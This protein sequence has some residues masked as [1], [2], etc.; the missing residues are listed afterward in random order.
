MKRTTDRFLDRLYGYITFASEDLKLFQTKELA[1]LRQVSLS[2]IPT[3]ITP[4][5]VCASKFEHSIGVAHLARMIGK[6]PEFED[7]AQDLFMAALTHDIGTPPFSHASELFLEKLYKKNHEE[8]AREIIDGSEFEKEAKRQGGDIDRI[9]AFIEGTDEPM[10]DI[11]NGSID[12]DNL[13]NSLRFGLSMGIV[14]SI[15]YSPEE[16]AESYRMVDGELVLLE[17]DERNLDGWDWVRKMVYTYVYSEMNLA[18]G[19]VLIRAMDYAMRANELPYEYFMMTDAQ[20]FEYLRTKTNSKTQRLLDWAWRMVFFNRAYSYVSMKSNE[21]FDKALT[22][23][24]VRSDIADQIAQELKVDPE[25]VCVHV[26]KN[27]GFKKI[28]LPIINRYGEKEFRTPLNELTYMVQVYV[29]PD[30]E[31]DE[32]VIENLVR[33]KLCLSS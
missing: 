10:S 4:T 6:K 7:V 8:F 32:Q 19:T 24:S 1:R 2:A 33:D 5:S 25:K 14:N 12:V 21:F 22:D 29:H 23:V 16:L 13:D 28:H 26:G 27:K 18:T 3:W 9:Q 20:A 17:P 30:M 15:V 31:V 11:I